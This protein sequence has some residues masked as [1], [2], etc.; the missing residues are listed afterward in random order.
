MSNDPPTLNAVVIRRIVLFSALAM[1]FQFT[2][3]VVRA[4]SD[5][6]QLGHMAIEQEAFALARGVSGER[7]YLSYTLP[8]GLR[9][10]YAKPGSGYYARIRDKKGDVLFSNCDESC[11]A[12]FLPLNVN[13]PTF[14][15]RQRKRGTPLY[16]DGGFLIEDGPAPILIEAAILGDKANVV[17]G[18][19]VHEVKDHMLT[20]M[21]LLLI[22]VVIVTTISITR[23]L[24]PV[25]RTTAMLPAVNPLDKKTRL[26]TDDLPL[27]IAQLTS[28]I[29]A[30]C[31]TVGD[32]MRAQRDFT[33]A[34]SHEVRTPLAIAHLELEKIDDPRA[35]K[36]EHD[37]ESLNQLVEQLTVLARLEG[38]DSLPTSA[39]DLHA[40]A[41][42]VVAA[43]APLV[44][45]AGK[46]IELIDKGAPRVQG[47]P[48]LVENAMRNLID[49]AIRHT[50]AG[51]EI[52]VEIG[53][54]P[55]FAVV[56]NCENCAPAR[57]A[58]ARRAGL[59]L[60]IVN[61]I[62]G[63]HRGALET[64]KSDN[65]MAAIFSFPAA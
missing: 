15:V 63:I 5:D 16:V 48:A 36:I 45:P 27:E 35:R 22:V 58:P 34:I 60:R 43:M 33:S 49:N 7:G 59:G 28:A 40:I 21:T 4:W 41:E 32:L 24:R 56:D 18:V 46:T 30:A 53:P 17:R 13:P 64:T 2:A 31:D 9:D 19:L 65:G 25:G 26:S 37:L 51:T 61:R 20:P 11:A 3:V 57:A 52:R 12:Q 62:A 6:V 54:G 47:H 14:W 38:A 23:A 39:L 1:L 44:Y 10:R 29:N 50:R 55:R 42:N 8:S